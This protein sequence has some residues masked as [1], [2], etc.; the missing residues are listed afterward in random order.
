MIDKSK[1]PDLVETSLVCMLSAVVAMLG[2]LLV[3]LI[4]MLAGFAPA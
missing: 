1:I 2:F 4:G 3:W